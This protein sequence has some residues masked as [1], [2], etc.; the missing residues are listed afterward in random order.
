MEEKILSINIDMGMNYNGIYYACLEKSSEDKYDIKD[1]S[2]V[3]ISL[4]QNSINYS[5]AG[6]RLKRHITAGYQREKL[7]KRLF[8]EIIDIKSFTEKQQEKLHGLFKNRGFTYFTIS[9]KFE[10]ADDLVINFLKQKSVENKSSIDDQ[11]QKQLQLQAKIQEIYSIN[12]TFLNK[13]INYND[14]ESTAPGTEPSESVEETNTE[15]QESDE[16]SEPST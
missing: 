4:P 6:R 11:K 5:K 10:D 3:C 8:D 2:A 13:T 14:H 1:K 7:A 12:E 9:N 15:D 16:S